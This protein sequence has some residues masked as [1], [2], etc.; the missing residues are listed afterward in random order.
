MIATME[1]TEKEDFLSEV[2]QLFE[3]QTRHIVGVL[4]E[5]Y[6]DKIKLV[7]EQ[8]VGLRE[9]FDDMRKV[10]DSHTNMIEGLIIDV[11]VIR[12]DLNKKA[13]ANDLIALNQR[14]HL[15]EKKSS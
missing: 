11:A 9:E 5:H 12:V 15:L 7:V 10:L 3:R 4:T 14:V 8:Y 13:H 1:K 2:G 6:D